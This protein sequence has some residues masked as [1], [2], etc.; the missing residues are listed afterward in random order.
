MKQTEEQIAISDC[1][2]KPGHIVRVKAYAGGGKSSTLKFY[3]QNHPDKKYLYLCYNATMASEAKTKFPSN[4]ACMTS[5]ALA[6]RATASMFPSPKEIGRAMRPREIMDH[7]GIASPKMGVWIRDTINKF[8][9]STQSEIGTVHTAGT[10]C[11]ESQPELVS[12]ARKLWNEMRDPK[13]RV[14]MPHDGYLKIFVQEGKPLTGYDAIMLD[15]SQDTNPVIAHYVLSQ[16][17]EYGKGL[18][19]VGD[20]HQSIYAFRGATNFMDSLDEESG[21]VQDFRLTTSFRLTQ[22]TADLASDILNAWK[23]D[24]VRIIGARKLSDSA[25]ITRAF[26]A[27][28]N[29]TLIAYAAALME[30]GVNKLHFAAT[31]DRQNYNPSSFY[32]FDEV[33]DVWALKQGKR[34]DLRTPYM[35]RFGDYDELR[36]MAEGRGGGAKDLELT[37]LI[38]LVD[39]FGNRINQILDD[40]IKCSTS[41]GAADRILSSAHRS[42]GLE[43]D[44][45]TLADDFIDLSDGEILRDSMTEQDFEQEINL[46]YVAVTRSAGTLRISKSLASWMKEENARQDSKAPVI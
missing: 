41:S 46:L 23:G 24:R 27:R 11:G 37:K 5:H 30:D 39:K 13:S 44:T 25:M 42:K 33:R 9:C 19:M 17:E 4:V 45:V 10:R 18:L 15:E 14:P 31:T 34:A 8:L 26:I 2:I 21:R 3:A 32:G 7:M 29:A 28:R 38:G 40:I 20:P 1:E 43:W 36:E 22:S 6:R 35:K 12:Y 16:V